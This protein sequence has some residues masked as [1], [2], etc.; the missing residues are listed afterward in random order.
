M[1][2]D[3]F[4]QLY[5]EQRREMGNSASIAALLH[6]LDRLSP[7]GFAIALHIT[8]TTPRYMFQTYAQRWLDRYNSAGL[9]LRDPV[10]QWGMQNVGRVRWSDLEAMD[11]GGVF[12]EARDYGLM[13]GA[14]LSL[15]VSGSRSIGGFA[16]ADREYEDAEMRELEDLLLRLHRDTA[17]IERFSERDQRA[18]TELSIKLTH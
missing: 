3:A 11:S 5:R 12:D 16:R 17:Q 9:L 4:V 7:S 8:F 13:N 18:L 10:V 6:E 1:A 14:A 15:V 2:A